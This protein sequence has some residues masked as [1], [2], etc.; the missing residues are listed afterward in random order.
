MLASTPAI[1]QSK[2]IHVH[3]YFVEI[4]SSPKRLGLWLGLGLL[5]GLGLGVNRAPHIKGLG[6]GVLVGLGLGVNRAPHI[7]G[8]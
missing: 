7:K 2:S 6:L 4:R 3:N 1:V 5:V 8:F